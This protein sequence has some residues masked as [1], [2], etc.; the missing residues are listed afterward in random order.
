MSGYKWVRH[1]G[2][3]AKIGFSEIRFCASVRPHR[4]RRAHQETETAFQGKQ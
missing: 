1:D 4:N 2:R 3:L